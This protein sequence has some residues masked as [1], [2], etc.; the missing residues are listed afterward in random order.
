MLR[1]LSVE[2]YALIDKLEIEF[3]PKLNTITGETGAG[4]S[5]LLGALSLVMGSRADSGVIKDESRNCVVEAEFDIKGYD[6]NE[7]F[8]ALELEYSPDTIIRR[9]ISA[10]GKS[11]AYINDLPVQL[12]TLKELAEHL[13]DIHSQHQTLLLGESRFQRDVLD[14]VASNSIILETYRQAY[15]DFL[16]TESRLKSLK[17]EIERSAKDREFI[18]YQLEQLSAANLHEGEQMELESELSELSHATQIKE[19][20]SEASQMLGGEGEQ[21]VLSTLK[22]IENS[23][24]KLDKVYSRAGEIASRIH[25]AIAELKDIYMEVGDEADRIDSDPKRLE[26]VEQRL[27]MIYSLQT[28]HKVDSVE[29]L[30]ELQADYTTRLSNID[31]SEAIL[32]QLEDELRA[33][34]E[35]VST[36]AAKV[37]DSRKSV[38]PKIEKSVMETLSQLG[39][40]SAQLKIEVEP[41]GEFGTDGADLVRF[42]F[43]ANRNIAMQPIEK[44]ASG[45][46]MSRLMLSL[47]QI[48]AS[49]KKLPAIIFDEI[50]TGVSGQIA[51]KIG[52]IITNFAQKLQVINITHLPQVASKGDHH[53]LV[54]KSEDQNSTKTQIRL[55]D[56]EQRLQQIAAMLSGSNITQAALDQAKQLL[57][58]GRI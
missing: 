29:A 58:E 47:K 36:L 45:G 23:F 18:A 57:S 17:N 1:R 2:N 20:L 42:M 21:V 14:S 19:S 16:K 10:S 26:F 22:G 46:E 43:S 32:E 12:T 24:S 7:L 15:R 39:M 31:N 51:G 37:T 41:L 33:K 56:P 55:L 38:V 5:I 13:I 3:S 50:D 54:Y 27:D 44:V 4:K 28:K 34:R 53:F 11:R 52:D 48:V 35:Q 6:L 9:V 8:D 30:M 40:M 49:H 25:A